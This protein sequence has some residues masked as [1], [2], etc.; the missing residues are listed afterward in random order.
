MPVLELKPKQDEMTED[1]MKVFDILVKVK[2]AV[3]T[4]FQALMKMEA[5]VE[6]EG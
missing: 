4:P 1:E 5:L 2:D 6:N 3:L